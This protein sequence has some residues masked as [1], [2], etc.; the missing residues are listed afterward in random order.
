[1]SRNNCLFWALPRWLRNYL[2]GEAL[3]IRRSTFT[4]VPHFMRAPC[5]KD[6]Y[7]EEY[8]PEQHP[9]KRLL[10]WFPIQASVFRGLVREGAATCLCASCRANA[11]PPPGPK[12]DAR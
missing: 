9:R 8:I 11:V 7:V 3:V 1:M 4:W 2:A 5:I 12:S 10:R 6:L